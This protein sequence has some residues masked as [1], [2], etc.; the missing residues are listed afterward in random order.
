MPADPP[1]R[2]APAPGLDLSEIDRSLLAG[3][4]AVVAPV[5]FGAKAEGSNNWAVDGSLSASGRPMLAIAGNGWGF[6]GKRSG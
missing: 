1:V 6:S 5:G 3:Y 2:Y 4:E